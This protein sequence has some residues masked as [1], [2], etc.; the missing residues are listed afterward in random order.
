MSAVTLEKAILPPE[1]IKALRRRIMWRIMPFS[2]LCYFMAQL[3][4]A[5]IS[6]A[7][8]QMKDELQFS[9]AVYG[10]GAG[11][12][13]IGYFLLEIPGAMIAERYSARLWILRIMTTWGLISAAM[14]FV[15]TPG[16]F[17]TLRF[18]LGLAEAGFFPAMMVV[19][20]RWFVEQDRAK[21]IAIF[22]GALTVAS[23]LG[24]PLS[25]WMLTLDW[26]GWSG[27][28]WMFVLQGLPSVL[29]GILCIWLLPDHPSQVRWLSSLEADYLKKATQTTTPLSHVGW[30]E[31]FALLADSR[32]A[33]LSLT[34][35]FM[36]NSVTGYNTWMPLLIKQLGE[37]SPTQAAL[38]AIVPPTLGFASKLAA[39]WSSDRF[40]ERYWHT[41]GL[42][43]AGTS[44]I[45]LSAWL[46]VAGYP[47]GALAMLFL[48]ATGCL[49]APPCFWAY[50]THS[51]AGIAIAVSIGTI[52]M[53]GSL[54]SAVGP[55]AFGYLKEHFGEPFYSLILLGAMQLGA[56]ASLAWIEHSNQKKI[57]TQT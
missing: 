54:G 18:L 8:L 29:V 23:I 25:A 30:K 40:E 41:T 38:W 28:R 13:Y 49:G 50:A 14:C 12:F 44:F 5:N 10:L 39:G 1:Q 17:Y 56:A 7:A 52:N 9:D 35:F 19:L 43:L 33:L 20:R 11:I 15:Q 48:G 21:A 47:L 45:C 42:L 24:S 16:Q 36:Q 3:D 6:Y 27:W 34:Y 32:I 4:R 37:L 2:M 51:G 26:L 57:G 53:I 31:T 46:V 55:Y 22:M